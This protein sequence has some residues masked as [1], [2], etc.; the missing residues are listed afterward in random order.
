MLAIFHAAHVRVMAWIPIAAGN[1][2]RKAHALLQFTQVSLEQRMQVHRQPARFSA[3][4]CRYSVRISAN[5]TTPFLI[6]AV[7]SAFT[8]LP[9]AESRKVWRSESFSAVC[10]APVLTRQQTSGFSGSVA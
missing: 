6:K 4:N 1:R 5:V 2:Q 8:T 9:P 7:A 3:H 10:S